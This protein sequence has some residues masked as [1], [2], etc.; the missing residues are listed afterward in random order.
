[1][2]TGRSAGVGSASTERA[3]QVL[4][5]LVASEQPITLTELARRCDMALAT[6]S[7][8]AVT[9][10]ARGYAHRTVIGR[11]HLWRPSLKLYGLGTMTL[12]RVELGQESEPILNQLRDE[13]DLPA[14][15]GIMDGS[16]VVY[17]AKAAT[18]AMVQFNTYPGKRA[19]YNLTALG[20]AIA[21]FL[22]PGKQEEL[23]AS[24]VPGSGPRA[25]AA[26]R[27]VLAQEFENIRAR[28]YAVENQEEDAGVACIAAPVL[29]VNKLAVASVGVTGFD[30]QLLAENED[31]VA[32]CVRAAALSLAARIGLHD[33]GSGTAG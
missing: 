30:Y 19:A 15:L 21:A 20:R 13:V 24:A 16:S 7:A 32:A 27:Q 11:S 18:S 23:I 25:T 22:P 33:L 26:S 2:V 4:E 6:C 17:V 29:D 5:A 10:E 28:G 31:R 3:L 8:V 1:M 14:H 12:R 9:L